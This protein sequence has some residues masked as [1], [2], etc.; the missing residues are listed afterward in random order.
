R[1][2]VAWLPVIHGGSRPWC[3]TNQVLGPGQ[4]NCSLASWL[5]GRSHSR[6]SNCAT[7]PATRIRPFSTGRCLSHNSRSTAS[8]FQGLHLWPHTAT[9][10]WAISPPAC[11]IRRTCPNLQPASIVHHS[12]L[13]EAT[14][15]EPAARLKERS[16]GG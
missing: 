3:G 5:C 13:R 7:L 9:V 11:R 6:N 2:T 14:L 4:D 8:A 12:D 16:P 15:A 10:G 1:A